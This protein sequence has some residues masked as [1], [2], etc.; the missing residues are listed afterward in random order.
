MKGRLGPYRF[1]TKTKKKTLTPKWREEFK[2]PI[3]TWDSQNLL[4]LE[5]HDKDHIF[6][7]KLGYVLLLN[8]NLCILSVY[9]YVFILEE[10]G[11]KHHCI[12]CH[13]SPQIEGSL[14]QG[15]CL[16]QGT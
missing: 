5:V 7:D 11:A 2:I 12:K 9:L 16:T 3:C 10:C 15:N 6:D 1:R 14:L 13:R 4:H 8:L